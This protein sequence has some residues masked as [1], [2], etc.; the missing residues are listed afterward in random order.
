[1]KEQG[2]LRAVFTWAYIA[3]DPPHADAEASPC[4]ARSNG[5]RCEVWSEVKN[6]MSIDET[7]RN[8]IRQLLTVCE[9][10]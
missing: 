7:N 10:A 8:K 6:Q 4:Y 2:V 9:N 5:L 3:I 1:M